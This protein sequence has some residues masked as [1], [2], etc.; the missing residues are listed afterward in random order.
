[1]YCNF[2][3]DIQ[4]ECIMNFFHRFSKKD[5]P[6]SKPVSEESPVA[7]PTNTEPQKIQGILVLSRDSMDQSAILGLTQQILDDQKSRGH[8]VAEGFL[9]KHFAAGADVDNDAYMYGKI[10][11]EFSQ[12]G[13]AELLN[14]TKAFPFHFPGGTSG[15]FYVIYDRR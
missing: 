5:Q 8:A 10:R 15:K 6:K 1:M 13:G 7:E 12:F 2:H 4:K 11:N 9:A 3:H 14:R